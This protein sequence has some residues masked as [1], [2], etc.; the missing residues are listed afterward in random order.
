MTW[1][2][3]YDIEYNTIGSFQNRDSNT[4]GYYIFLWTGNSYTSQEIYICHA[5]IPPVIIPEGDLVS[6][7]K[8]MTPIIKT[9]YLYH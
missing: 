5:F 6:P 8:F 9:S 1:A 3:A 7:A 4:P 2:V